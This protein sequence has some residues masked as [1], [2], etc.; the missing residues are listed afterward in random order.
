MLFTVKLRFL[1]HKVL[2]LQLTL[3]LYGLPGSFWTAFTD[4]E[5]V[6][7]TKWALVLC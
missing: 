2:Q 3:L 5:P 4:L 1:V 7:W 6:L